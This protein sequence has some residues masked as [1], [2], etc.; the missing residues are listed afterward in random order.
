MSLLEL[1][2][3]RSRVDTPKFSLPDL[4]AEQALARLSN[5]ETAAI[6]HLV[7][8]Y[9]SAQLLA[10]DQNAGRAYA[11]TLLDQ[12]VTRSKLLYGYIPAS[13]AYLG[14]CWEE[15]DLSFAQ[16]THGLGQL[17]QIS[18][19]LGAGA[20]VAPGLSAA[21]RRALLLRTPGE[22]HILG[23][24]LTAHRLRANGWLV[25]ID[26]GGDLAELSGRYRGS[27]FDIIG[28]T[29]SAEQRLDMLAR[30]AERFSG[31]CPDA[32][33]VL[34]GR[35]TT[36]ADPVQSRLD[37]F[38]IIRPDQKPEQELARILPAMAD[39]GPACAGATAPGHMSTDSS[40]RTSRE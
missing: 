18:R 13:A 32:R 40:H 4:L 23:L 6:H 29:A 21:P 38:T 36:L 26:L 22:E 17:M 35:I 5:T 16:V 31:A 34:G 7:V 28:F 9:F 39:P 37:A 24:T 2:A 15:D 12:G 1:I 3:R 30:V 27:S 10:P 19:D 33:L 25:G 8:Q 14:K 20:P 11:E